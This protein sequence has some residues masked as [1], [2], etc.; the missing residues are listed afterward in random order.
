MFFN[1]LIGINIGAFLT[2]LVL[3]RF[4]KHEFLRLSKLF[5][6]ILERKVG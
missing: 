4:K 3:S 1:I 2:I 6:D 5:V